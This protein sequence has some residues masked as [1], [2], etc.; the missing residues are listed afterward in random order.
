VG[1]EES[2]ACLRVRICGVIILVICVHDKPWTPIV[3]VG[4]GIKQVAGSAPRWLGFQI[5]E[6]W[7]L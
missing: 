1:R 4:V 5:F 2:V 3:V 6:V 7:R